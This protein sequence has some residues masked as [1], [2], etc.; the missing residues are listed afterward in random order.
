LKITEGEDI[1]AQRIITAFGRVDVVYYR[2]ERGHIVPDATIRIADRWRT[3]D[4]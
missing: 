4:A 1:G 3:I 2:V